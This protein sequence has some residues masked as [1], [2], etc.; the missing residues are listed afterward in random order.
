MWPSDHKQ[1][2]M[3]FPQDGAMYFLKTLMCAPIRNMHD[4]LCAGDKLKSEPRILALRVAMVINVI[5]HGAIFT[6][7]NLNS[8][9]FC[10]TYCT[11]KLACRVLG[12]CPTAS[13]L[14]RVCVLNLLIS[15][16]ES[17][18]ALLPSMST[19][20]RKL[21]RQQQHIIV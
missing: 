13:V 19:H 15:E 5:G 16:S 1:T 7:L 2:R 14:F 8:A 17:E 18:G 10:K 9:F 11:A 4:L 3:A 21:T 12:G 6:Q 20:T